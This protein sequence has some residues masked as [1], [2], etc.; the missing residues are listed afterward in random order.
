MAKL[1]GKFHDV[2]ACMDGC[3]GQADLVTHKIDTGEAHPIKLPA[4]RLPST[5]KIVVEEEV[6]KMLKQGIVEPSDSP[7][8]APVCLATKKDGSIRFSIDFRKLNSVTLRDAYPL[9]R[10]DDTL[11]NL[12]GAQ[13]FS[14]LDLASGYWLV[15]KDKSKT[16][17]T[18]HL[19]LSL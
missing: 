4:R 16:A 13:W 11:E 17:F 3:I 7:W 19:G 6:D 18:T 1:V 9:S 14:T 8:S 2:F 15:E 10:I 5:S 12:S